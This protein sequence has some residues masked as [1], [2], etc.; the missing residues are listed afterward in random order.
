M[1]QNIVILLDQQYFW[2]EPRIIVNQSN[3][4]W[5]ESTSSLTLR[6]DFVKTCLWIPDLVFTNAHSINVFNP[7]PA[8]LSG[9][10][11]KYS[12]DKDGNIHAW[13]RNTEVKVSC[14]LDFGSYPFDKQV[15]Y[16]RKK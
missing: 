9:P 3:P 11:K 12:I 16:S 8:E 2:E 14:S 13:M 10:A 5:T 4:F 15:C 6:G 7:S 1:K